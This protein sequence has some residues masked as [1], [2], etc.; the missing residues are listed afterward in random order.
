[1]ANKGMTCNEAKPSKLYGLNQKSMTIVKMCGIA[2]NR[3]GNS[4]IGLLKWRE[5]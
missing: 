4:V 2:T 3:L 5:N 1:M